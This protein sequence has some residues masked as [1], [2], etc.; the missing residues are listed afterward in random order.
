VQRRLDNDRNKVSKVKGYNGKRRKRKPY[1]QKQ[2][3]HENNNV[4]TEFD[5]S[6]R[7]SFPIKKEFTDLPDLSDFSDQVLKDYS[8]LL[9]SQGA[10]YSN[11][12]ENTADNGIVTPTIQNN[13]NNNNALVAAPAALDPVP[14]PSP[15]AAADDSDD[16]EDVD[17]KLSLFR[18]LKRNASI[19]SLSLIS[20]LSSPRR[21]Y[22]NSPRIW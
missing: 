5:R 9:D 15:A 12:F 16:A 8:S 13:Y 18:N 11:I 21:Y 19:G 1:I 20:K 17:L 10:K 7:T 14:A 4:E 3:Q 6:Q 2:Q 22:A